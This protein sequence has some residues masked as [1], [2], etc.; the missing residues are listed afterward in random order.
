ATRCTASLTLVWTVLLERTVN[1]RT[2]TQ[3][4]IAS[5]MKP[6]SRLRPYRPQMSL[7]ATGFEV[8]SRGG[9]LGGF[10]V[11][12]RFRMSDLNH[13]SSTLSANSR[14]RCTSAEKLELGSGWTSSDM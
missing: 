7:T 13:G 14:C 12:L 8:T 11:S 5:D 1:I 10:M 4:W 3:A 2:T 6:D 9:S